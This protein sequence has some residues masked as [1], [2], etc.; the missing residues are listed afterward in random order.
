MGKIHDRLIVKACD[1][2]DNVVASYFVYGLTLDDMITGGMMKKV[3]E[4]LRAKYRH[5]TETEFTVQK[6]DYDLPRNTVKH[7]VSRAKAYEFV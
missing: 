3:F 5:D 1:A 2:D 7:V 6:V 4:G